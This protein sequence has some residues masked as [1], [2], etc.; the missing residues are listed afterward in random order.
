MKIRCWKKWLAGIYL[1][2]FPFFGKA[3]TVQ[4]SLQLTLEKAIAIAMSENPSVKVA[5]LEIKKK[6]YAK[7]SAQSALYPQIDVVGQYTRTLKKQVMYM[8]GAFDM[9]SM[10]NPVILPLYAGI[11]QT[12]QQTG[13][14]PGDFYNYAKAAQEAYDAANP[15]QTSSDG[16]ISVGRDNNWT[17]GL[18]LSWPVVVPTLW[19]TL[20]ISS[21][22]VE[23]AVESARS[24]KVNLS[25]D[26]K[27]AYY[28]VMLAQDS[29]DVFRESYDNALSNYNNIKQK[30][31]QG[32]ASEFE[33]I[34][35]D[36]RVKNVK[37]NMIQAQNALSLASLSLKA[38][39]GIDLDQAVKPMGS[40]KDYEENIYA[41]VIQADTSLANNS[42]LRQLDL[43]S[44]QLQKTL[45]L[46]KAQYW[47]TVAI[48]GQYVYM[49]MNNDFRFAD[50]K[51]NPYSTVGLSVSIPLFDGFKKRS[52]VRQ[53]RVSIEQM[54]YQREE[55][56]KNLTLSVKNGINSMT[57]YVEQVFSTKGVVKQAQKGYDISLKRYDTGMGTLL[58]L[59][60][61]QVAHIQ[62]SLAYNQAIYN[63]LSSKADLAK[64]LGLE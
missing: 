13:L 21:L 48:T 40:L 45:Q 63:Y 16:G 17:G 36:V 59:N 33:V 49:S 20:D 42:N 52:D 30:F 35:A 60:D 3:Q 8:D 29:Y 32:L 28:G 34:T 19:K 2:A 37:P 47:P 44:E 54:K 64:T 18:N 50:Y 26:V 4:D 61:A 1:L 25:N 10:L 41:D 5:G 9:G 11:D 14:Q 57:N 53:T 23:L 43:R 12:F 46:Y 22:D 7:Q 31:D 55:L 24:S 27:K 39:M 56:V 62:A 51:W 6:E 15:P 58:E 38:L